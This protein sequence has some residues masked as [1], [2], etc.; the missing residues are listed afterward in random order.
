MKI[1]ALRGASA[2]A[3]LALGG[4][5]LYATSIDAA[6]HAEAPGSMADAAADI[7]DFYAW[8]TAE[9]NVVSIITF[10]PMTAAGGDPTY[11]PDV[12]YTVNQAFPDKTGTFLEFDA[13]VAGH[14]RFGEDAEGNWG[15]QATLDTPI[16]EIVF[17]G[18]V[19]EMIEYEIAEGISAKLWVGLADD[20]FFFDSTGFNDTLATGENLFDPS[21]DALAGTNVTAIVFEVAGLSP[22]MQT[23]ATT[24]RDNS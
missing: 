19:E 3:L 15:I 17:D 14:F 21:R 7:A 16:G 6:D 22:L 20:P 12:L 11:D 1:T 4:F 24:A 2:A 13:D 5:G 23:W 18:P 8:H 10:A 9:G